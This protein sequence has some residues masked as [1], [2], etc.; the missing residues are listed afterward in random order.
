MD[1]LDSYRKIIE[2]ILTESAQIPY[3]YGDIK[4]QFIKDNYF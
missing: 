3:K 2:K 4:T 1:A